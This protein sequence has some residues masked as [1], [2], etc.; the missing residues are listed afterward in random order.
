M[1][2]KEDGTVVDGT[3]LGK[4]EIVH[5]G[6]THKMEFSGT[7]IAPE[8][9]N[10]NFLLD[11]RVLNKLSVASSPPVAKCHLSILTP[12]PQFCDVV[13]SF[14]SLWDV[15]V[16][17]PPAEAIEDKKVKYFCRVH[18][19]GA[20]E[21]FESQMVATSIYYEAMYV[22]SLSACF[23]SGLSYRGLTDLTPV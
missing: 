14:S 4:L 20:L 11:A 21:H 7:K 8:D 15:G 19:G 2:R 17:W 12:E 6:D 18:P 9:Y 13:L 5:Q 22:P 10:P 23:T 3:F 16:S 1:A